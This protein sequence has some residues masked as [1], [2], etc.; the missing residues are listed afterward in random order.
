MK[1]AL[2]TSPI[3]IGDHVRITQTF[4]RRGARA[5]RCDVWEGVVERLDATSIV[6]ADGGRVTVDMITSTAAEPHHHPDAVTIERAV[7]PLEAFLLEL[8][9]LHTEDIETEGMLRDLATGRMTS[10]ASLATIV[11]VLT[12]AADLVRDSR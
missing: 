4:G 6:L 5:S 8:E 10:G 12:A 3:Q 1:Y 11:K 2:A 7:S 9:E